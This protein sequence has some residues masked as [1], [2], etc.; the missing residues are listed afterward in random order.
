MSAKPTPEE[1]LFAVIQ[2]AAHPP[3]R[4]KRSSRSILD[5]GRTAW[6]MAGSIGVPQVNH[7]LVTFN[8]LLALVCVAGAFM[9]PDERKLMGLAA[10]SPGRFTI[11]PPLAGMQPVEELVELMRAKDPFHIAEPIATVPTPNTTP[12]PPTGPDFQ[13][14]LSQLKLVGIARGEEATAMI[15]DKASQQTHFLRRGETIGVFTIKEVLPDHVI[16]RAGDQDFDLF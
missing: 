8:I 14:A 4:S 6:A 11:A 2:G 5:M 10:Q 1:K 3:L 15:E 16:L 12:P 7:A 9:R 13:A